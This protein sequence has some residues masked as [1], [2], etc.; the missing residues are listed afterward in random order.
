MRFQLLGPL[1]IT[2]GCDVAVL[3]PAKPTS[4][5][6]ALLVRPGEVVPTQRLRQAVWGD[7][8]PAT[9]KAALQSCVLRL[10]RLFAK[11]DIEEQAVV[12]V[13]GGYR[14]PAD[15]DTLDLLHFRGLV[16]EAA[17]AGESELP[18]L[19]TAL[20]LWQ[21]PLLANVPSE[22]LHRDEVPRLVEERLRVLERVC[23]IQLARGQS[24]E[25]LVDLWE[26]TR[27]H[28]QHE[29]LAA[30]LM[31]ALYR[32]GR[33]IEALAEYRRIRT[34]LR[35]ELGVDPGA[36]LQGLELAIL[37]GDE[38]R[39]PALEAA[40]LTL[41]PHAAPA[42]ADAAPGAPAARGENTPSGGPVLPGDGRPPS[43]PAHP[44][45]PRLPHVPGFTGRT[46][47][48]ADLVSHLSG[49][50]RR[51]GR[52]DADPVIAVISGGPGMGK[53][54][55]A[56]HTAQLVADRYPAGGVLLPLTR[57][58]G[59]PRSADEAAAE[60]RSAL[61]SGALPGSCLVILDDVVHP[62]QVRGLLGMTGCG[63]FVVTSRMR[64][65]ALVA[66]HGPA[67]LEL[68][69]LP[70]QESHA[71]LVAVL[72]H[73][74]VAA[75][76]TAAHALTDTCGHV[77][78]ALR[79]VAARLLTRPKLRLADHAAW[80]RRD[81]PAR[82]ALPDDVRMSVPLTLDGALDRLPAPVADAHLCLARLDGQITAPAAARALSV[83]ETHAEELLERLL[84]TG[85]L[86]E[87]HPGTL[88]MN[89]LFRAHALHRAARTGGIP[90]AAV[91]T[92]RRALPSG[93]T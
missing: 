38:P 43:G 72:G 25:V 37:R 75:E 71:L 40:P 73:E 15:G 83:P 30:Q 50:D 3:P 19:R 64:L 92:A 46:R 41:T 84:D 68:G 39:G 8:Q 35:E 17:G 77:P 21:G 67:V 85:L 65:A 11:Y 57:P 78:L 23:E 6:A 10:R 90:Q 87:E 76:T 53:T 33:Q 63:A 88:R 74:R 31:R 9:A 49:E 27:T 13:A 70:P 59:T 48:T 16:A 82:L 29:G 47:E 79:I 36:E 61:P 14:L 93:A 7:E 52:T 2:D 69:A 60:L 54:A 58:D 51:D 22:L 20:D 91:A 66:T 80:L 12:A 89:T 1:S 32:A 28:P 62:D 55:L 34:H 42:V 56:L 24:R 86:D 81:L 44:P 26:A 5:L 45:G 4:L 18:L